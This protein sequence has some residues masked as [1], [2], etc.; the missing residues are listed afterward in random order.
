M[1]PK[2]IHY[3]WLGGKPKPALVNICILSW[4]EKMPDFQ[5]VEWNES[6]LDLDKIAKENRFFAECRK[7]KMWA[8]MADYLR[9]KVLYQQGGI[10]LDTD[11]QVIK[12][13]SPLLDN[14]GFI[15]MESEDYISCGIIACHAGNQL[16][17]NV[18]KYYDEQI[19]C[20]SIY[21]IPSVFTKVFEDQ[22][23]ILLLKKI[24]SKYFYPYTYNSHFDVDCLTEDTYTIHWW[25]GSWNGQLRPYLFLSTKH[26][27]NPIK[28]FLI[29]VKKATGFYYKKL[30]VNRLGE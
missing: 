6:N 28:K 1:I 10:Y 30:F 23:S 18:L 12:S 2:I 5:I 22:S 3:I 9:L 11:M 4:K 29:S 15:G 26:I 8:F 16:I 17:G 20:N 13:L 14:L 24:P 27:C 25:A 7:R 21:T 19:W